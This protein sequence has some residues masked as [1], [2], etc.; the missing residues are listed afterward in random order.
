MNKSFFRKVG[1]GLGV[2]ESIPS[3][4]LEWSISQI[5]KLPKLNWSGPIY[6]LKEMM[7]FH[8]KYNYQDR[9]VLRK[10]YKNS[11]KD[12]KRARKLLQYQT[13]HYYFEPLWL[14]IRCSF[15]LLFS[16]VSVF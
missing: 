14:Y 16:N 7:E 9:R 5:E 2:D 3:N 4:P 15:C 1:F 11:R 10:K 6:S 13:G 12:Y 8:G